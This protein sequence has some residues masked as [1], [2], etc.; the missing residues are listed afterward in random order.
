MGEISLASVEQSSGLEQINQAVAQMDI[1]TQQNAGLVQDLGLTVHDL[2]SEAQAL[3]T[4]IGALNTGRNSSAIGLQSA[5]RAL[6]GIQHGNNH[7]MAISAPGHA[8]EYA[9]Q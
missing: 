1:V 8:L 5:T 2:T 4:A 6:S 3:N 9:R 7:A